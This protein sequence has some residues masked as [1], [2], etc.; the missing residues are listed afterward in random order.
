MC[1]RAA[2]PSPADVFAATGVA[3]WV[4]AE[5]YAQRF[6]AAPGA[7]L[8]VLRQPSAAGGEEPAADEAPPAGE[9]H[10]QSMRWGLVPPGQSEEAQPDF[11]RMF[12]ARVE[13]VAEKPVFSRL[14]SRKRGV[15]LLSGFYEW[16]AEGSGTLRHKQ[17]YYATCAD[18]AEEPPLLR[19]A[20]L[21]DTWQRRSGERLSTVTLLTKDAAPAN[22]WLHD[23]QPIFL[24]AADSLA[25]LS[26]VQ[27]IHRMARE[28]L[29]GESPRPTLKWHPVSTRINS[30]TSG[31]EGP[32]CCAL[33]PRAAEKDAGSLKALF[34]KAVAKGATPV[35]ETAAEDGGRKR[36]SEAAP[37]TGQRTLKF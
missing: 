34:A 19:A 26:D 15:A 36:K 7:W 37:E 28:P 14:L 3:C 8:A 33:A 20:A 35:K 11:F 2:L 25:W 24:S 29:A 5:Q 9:L 4:D 32:E 31:A 6:N 18:E 27:T 21:F 16:R 23:R 10:L 17:P 22:A 30:I 13:T 1:G 12:N